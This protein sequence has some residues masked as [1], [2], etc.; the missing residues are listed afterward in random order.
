MGEVQLVQT[1]ADLDYYLKLSD[2]L[3][4]VYFTRGR[5]Q[6]FDINMYPA[7]A[8]NISQA[9]FLKV[10]F[11]GT[12]CGCLGVTKRYEVTED[13]TFVFFRNQAEIRGERYMDWDAPKLEARIGSLV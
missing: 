13:P 6:N 2:R 9:I 8:K 7:M 5:N 12:L 10:Y 4:V 11:S 1:Q 3:V